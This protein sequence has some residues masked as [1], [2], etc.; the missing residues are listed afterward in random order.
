MRILLFI[1][2]KILEILAVVFIPYGVGYVFTCYYWG[3]EYLD[4]FMI[5][6]GRGV[7]VGIVGSGIILFSVMAVIGLVNLVQINWE[8]SKKIR[9]KLGT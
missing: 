5:I 4:S 9:E 7:L 3:K 6:W 8:W 1:L 2:L